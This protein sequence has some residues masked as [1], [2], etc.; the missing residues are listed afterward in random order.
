MECSF[1]CLSFHFLAGDY[2]SDEKGCSVSAG[3]RIGAMIQNGK[4]A[5]ARSR[6]K[7]AVI[8]GSTRAWEKQ[9][10]TAR[11]DADERGSGVAVIARHRRNR[12]NR[13]NQN[14]PR[15]N[16]DD[17]DQE[18][19]DRKGKSKTLPRIDADERGS[20]SL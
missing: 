16:T 4:A 19:G 9:N 8:A 11:I 13:R 7:I 14:L 10:L 18:I 5:H 6:P 15:M 12:R 2:K 17:T 20:G 1:V 3:R